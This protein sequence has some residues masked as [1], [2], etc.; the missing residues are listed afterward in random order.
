M[1]DHEILLKKCQE[2]GLKVSDK[3]CKHTIKRKLINVRRAVDE[4]ARYGSK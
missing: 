1:T 2:L 4:L 3:T